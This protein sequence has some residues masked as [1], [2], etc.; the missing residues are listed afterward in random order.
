[1]AAILIS[2]S[3]YGERWNPKTLFDH[4]VAR[5]HQDHDLFPTTI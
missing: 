4:K 5:R 3:F 2:K 1:M